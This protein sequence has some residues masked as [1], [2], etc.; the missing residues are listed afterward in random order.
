MSQPVRHIAV[1]YAL[2]YANGSLHLGHMTGLV[3]T[4]I[5]VRFQRM[6]GAQCTYICGCDSHGTPIMIQAEKMNIAP[7]TL[8]EQIR[9]EHQVDLAGFYVAVDNY[10]TTHSP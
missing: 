6:M 10:H 5:W 1:T 2:I 3:Q 9:A 8:V 4:D 7:E